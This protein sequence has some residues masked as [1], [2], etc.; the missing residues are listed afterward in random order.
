LCTT[1]IDDESLSFKAL[2]LKTYFPSFL[3]RPFHDKKKEWKRRLWERMVRILKW[4]VSVFEMGSFVGKENA[5]V[6]WAFNYGRANYAAM[7]Q[8]GKALA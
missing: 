6:E 8:W 5:Q 4:R 1:N 7:S 3:W 2:L